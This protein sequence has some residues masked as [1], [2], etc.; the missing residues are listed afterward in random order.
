MKSEATTPVSS[1]AKK[2]HLSVLLLSGGILL[3]SVTGCSLLQETSEAIDD[4]IQPSAQAAPEAP[5]VTKLNS[6]EG[7]NTSQP[8]V[9]GT[10]QSTV[11]QP[12]KALPVQEPTVVKKEAVAKEM[13]VA[14]APKANSTKSSPQVAPKANPVPTQPSIIK[15]QVASTSSNPDQIIGQYGMWEL[16]KAWEGSRSHCEVRS[17]TMQVDDPNFTSQI[18]LSVEPKQ[19]VLNA[20]SEILLN[21]RG[22]GIRLDKGNLIPFTGQAISSHAILS[23]NLI[24]RMSNSQKLHLYVQIGELQSKVQHTEVNLKDL[25]AAVSAFNKCR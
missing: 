2:L 9:A 13:I 6:N 22:S 20:S 3:T 5:A 16:V 1:R 11:T 14:T 21:A 15:K 8:I 18:W 12:V 10:P 25:R 17:H 23:D 7:E 19:L 24:D 4:P